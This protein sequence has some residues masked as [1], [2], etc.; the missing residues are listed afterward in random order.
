MKIKEYL[1][2]I[3]VLLIIS[4]LFVPKERTGIAAIIIAIAA[5]LGLIYWKIKN[6]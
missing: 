3:I 2:M 1:L 6:K 4:I 5:I